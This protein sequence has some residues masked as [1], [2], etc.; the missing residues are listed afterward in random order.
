MITDLA[1][2]L[3]AR[4]QPLEPAMAGMLAAVAALITFSPI[5][6]GVVRHLLTLIHEAGHALIAVLTGRRLSGIRLHSDTSGLTVTKGR[7]RGL[8][9]VLT[10]LAGYP[11]PAVVALAGAV[12]LHQGYAATL[13]WGLVGLSALMLL[14]I[15]NFFGLWVVLAFGISFGALSYLAP[16][17]I[18]VGA[19]YVVTWTLLLAAPRAVIDLAQARRRPGGQGSDADQAARL[20]HIPAF[21]WVGV[22]FIAC[23]AALVVG[24]YLLIWG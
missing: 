1:A 9:M 23:L 11:A 3:V 16:S 20:T 18:V 14:M 4:N 7:P 17:H 10:A 19:A 15:R 13:L 21:V 8:G 2:R 22:F 12:A 24:G 6:Y 5:G